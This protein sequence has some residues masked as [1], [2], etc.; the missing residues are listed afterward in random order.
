ML[1]DS[2]SRN[3]MS[4]CEEILAPGRGW[5]RYI[6]PGLSIK[7]TSPYTGWICASVCKDRE[8]PLNASQIQI[9]NDRIDGSIGP[10]NRTTP[11]IRST[12]H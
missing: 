1:I 9:G 6:C 11:C 8:K 3:A 10:G 12:L 7:G 4:S 5:N 2:L